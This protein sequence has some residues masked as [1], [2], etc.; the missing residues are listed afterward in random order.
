MRGKKLY[1]S[2]QFKMALW[3]LL[4][5]VVTLA[6]FSY[7]QYTNQRRLLLNTLIQT[8]ANSAQ[9]I[10]G[11]LRH[12]MQT[13]DFSLMQQ[14]AD[15]ISEQ[16]GVV[17]LFVVDALGR[18]ILSAGERRTGAVIPLT[19]PTCQACH[20]EGPTK[21]N[22]GIVLDN[23]R[24]ARVFRDVNLLEGW[25]LC[26][27]CGQ[28][29]DVTAAVLI[30][31]FSMA[32]IDGQL[33]SL[34][35]ASLGWAAS[36]IGIM[37]LIVYGVQRQM[38]IARL[39]QFLRAMRKVSA[40]DFEQRINVTQNDEIAELAYR[41]NEMADGLQEKQHLE[42]RLKE[43]SEELQAQADRLAA[44]N[45]VAATINQ[46]LNL[47]DIL[48]SAL[49]RVLQ[50]TG[51]K[52]G[53]IVLRG[54]QGKGCELVA[55]R[56]LTLEVMTMDAQSA[57]KRCVCQVVAEQTG[58]NDSCGVM[59]CPCPGSRSGADGLSPV[60]VC[61]PLRSKDKVLG[62][63]ALVGDSGPAVQRLNP[64]TSEMLTSIGQQMGVAI[65][66][67]RLYEELRQKDA[68]RRH[69]LERVISVQ[70]EERRRIARELHD[71]TSQALT[72][73]LVRLQVL[74]Q[75]ASLPMVQAS[76]GELRAEVGKTLDRVHSLALELRPS[77][78]D[79]LGLVAALRRYFRDCEGRFRLPVDFQVLG[80]DEQRLS[81]Q[82]ETA[83]Y[84]IA[85]EALANVARHAE[86][87]SVSVLL[88]KR[89]QS[90]ALVVED[91]GKGFDVGQVM[92]SRP[93]VENL[94]LYGMQ[95]RAALLGGTVVIESSPGRGTS[96]FVEL[97]LQPEVNRG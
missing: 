82:V 83:L 4:P 8:A 84:R 72:S 65:E 49:E 74:E 73:L 7:L 92:G 39:A 58:T 81:S 10:E 33:A 76:L 15:G 57:W 20:R 85:Q 45:S 78:L 18:V 44:L 56:G 94:G 97:P 37:L 68:M 42:Q 63:M 34:A 29:G 64:G 35:R 50:L 80:L 48:D 69:L 40:G 66:N 51:V 28:W 14:I 32:T 60:R 52:G 93:G 9:I 55:S 59:D 23:Q 77:V 24:G 67:A 17:D 96:V 89:G 2:L 62:T 3:L 90:V 6:L 36:S 87:T 5:L 26:R 21:R 95:E 12:G 53:W 38:V 86:A 13:R 19:D 79:D 27:D 61:V 75:V 22:E 47:Q 11:S 41:F 46:S 70:E 30:T 31:D 25:E 16:R 71:E 1:Q 54:S 43:R 91:D 88:E